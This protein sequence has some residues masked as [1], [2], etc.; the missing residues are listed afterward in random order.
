MLTRAKRR[1]IEGWLLLAPVLAVMTVV[2]LYPLLRTVYL[3]FT[4]AML[5]VGH[6]PPEWIG[7]EN[8]AYVLTD[9]DFLDAILRTL[10]FTLGSVGAELVLGVLVGVLLNQKFYGRTLVRSIVILPW[11]LPTIVNAMLWRLIYNPEYGSLNALLTG[12]GLM[13]DYRSWLGDVDMAMTMVIIADVWKNYAIVA[14]VVLAALQTIPSELYEAMRIDGAGAWTRFWRLTI[15]GILG[16][17]T[18]AMVLRLIDSFRVFDII[19]VMTRGGPAD[20]TKTVSFY[21]Y[22]ESFAFLRA[23]SGASYAVIVAVMSAI[24]IAAYIFLL[25][26]QDTLT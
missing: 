23:G 9:P 7:V 24:L 14:L 19:F 2:T 8:Y 3:S 18:V 13:S 17:L 11:A 26:R 22:Q 16:P 1:S 4:D 21:V 15:P 25:K 20:A 6:V 12:L 10:H 5:P